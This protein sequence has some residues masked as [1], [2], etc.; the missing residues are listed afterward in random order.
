[1]D[2]Q[3][4]VR[5]HFTWHLR[6]RTLEL[7]AR[8]RTLAVLNLTPDSFS[9]G[10]L[11]F[12]PQ[13]ALTHALKL[14]DEGADILD[15]GGEST[16]PNATPLQAD[17]EIARVLPTLRAILKARPDAVLS[18]DTYHAQTARAAVEAGAEIVNDVSGHTWDAA[19]S[20]T[21]AE[22]GC[23]V[24]LMHTRGRPGQW[25][26]LPPIPPMARMPIVLTGL[27]D[28][29]L[30]ARK[31]GVAADRIVLD[32]G[33]GFGKLGDENYTVLSLLGQMHQFGLPIAVGLSRKGFLGRTLAQAFAQPGSSALQPQTVPIEGRLVAT[34]AAHVAAIL[35]GAHILR[36]HDVRAAREAAAIADAILEAGEAISKMSGPTFAPPASTTPQ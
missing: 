26:S 29:L 18:I 3:P 25:A 19:M 11:Y 22:L 32:P 14:L 34:Q 17:E 30:A 2:M 7:G 4:A 6:T 21:C 23:G 9:D 31:A 10:G 36:V 20:A 33:F 35:S 16:R 28:S 5:T 12:S 27:R 24:L 8:T 15:L 1:M 13:A